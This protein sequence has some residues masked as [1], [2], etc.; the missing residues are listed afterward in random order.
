MRFTDRL[1][2]VDLLDVPGL[3][4]TGNIALGFVVGAGRCVFPLIVRLVRILRARNGVQH[5]PRWPAVTSK[6]GSSRPSPPPSSTPAAVSKSCNWISP[7]VP[8]GPIDR[9]TG[10]TLW[11]RGPNDTPG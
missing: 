5:P 3:S 1:W 6:T 10:K 9:V 11:D 2:L 8:F 7:T 4:E